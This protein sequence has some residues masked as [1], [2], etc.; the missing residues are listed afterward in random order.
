MLLAVVGRDEALKGDL[1]VVVGMEEP[2][3]GVGWTRSQPGVW[4]KYHEGRGPAPDFVTHV[5]RAKSWQNPPVGE[6][7]TV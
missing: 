3:P 7:T 6:G 5:F 2:P 4:W 1:L